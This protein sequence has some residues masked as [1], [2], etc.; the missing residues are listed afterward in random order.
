MTYMHTNSLLAC[1]LPSPS[2]PFL[3]FYSHPC[4]PLHYAVNENTPLISHP[5]SRSSRSNSN[6]FVRSGF[7][8]SSDDWG[9][10]ID[11]A[12]VFIND[13]IHYRSI[14]HKIDPKSLRLYHIYHSWPVQ[15]LLG[16]VIF[17]I[18]VLA[19]FEYPTSLTLSS[20]FRFRNTTINIGNGSL[21]FSTELPCGVT[22]FIEIVCLLVFLANWIVQLCLIGRSRFLKQPWLVV[23]ALMVLL[24]F[25][26]LFVS[27]GFCIGEGHDSLGGNI[28]IRR[29][30]RPFFFI[31]P[32]SIMKKFIKAV[33]HTLRRIWSVF[34]V[35][36]L[37]IYVFAMIGMLVF[38]PSISGGNISNTSHNS[39]STSLFDLDVSELGADSSDVSF[40][41]EHFAAAEG[42][43]W[44]KSVEDALVSL[45]VFLTTANNP[46]FMTSIYQY[47]RFSFIYFFLFLSIGLY[48]ILNL[49]TAAIF[50]EFRGF[51]EQSMQSSFIRRRVGFRAAFQILVRS[52]GGRKEGAVKDIVR[53]LIH[54]AN[55]PKHKKPK[56]MTKLETA[57]TGSPYISWE[58]FRSMLDLIS[59]EEG[60]Q[61]TEKVQYYS[62]NRVVKLLQTFVRHPL[63]NYFTLA[64]TLLHVAILTILMEA[65]YYNGSCRKDSI[66]AHINFFFFFYYTA[67][68]LLK[69]LGLGPRRFFTSLSMVFEFL[70]TLAIFI[71]EIVI[72]AKFGF[73]F[74]KYE[75]SHQ[76]D[77]STCIPI[78]VM[79][80]FVV[81]RL[82][83]I[84][85][86]FNSVSLVVGTMFEIL[87]NL[88]AFAGIFIVIYYM[89]ALLGMELFQNVDFL[90]TMNAT[91]DPKVNEC[92]TY[93]NLGYFAYNFHDFASSLVLLWNVMVVN[94]WYVFLFAYARVATKWSQLYFIAWWL[95]SVI[96]TINLFISLIIEV[97]LTRWEAYHS[98]KQRQGSEQTHADNDSLITSSI[99][100]P[101]SVQSDVRVILR[102]SLKEPPDSELL[103]ELHRHNELL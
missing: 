53:Q 15:I 91:K 82:L 6:H 45:L 64:M 87:K 92:G 13:A 96:I 42:R 70:I 72:L 34:V 55:L 10:A 19:F 88:R 5:P 94:N 28:R 80:V 86:V 97:F 22:E 83:R 27:L 61:T 57:N 75:H 78:R 25:I 14:H 58:E 16:V 46:D 66:L 18:L 98:W 74:V 81:L 60:E 93:E 84:I 49:F 11:Q 2:L 23:Y 30:F 67:E 103:H 41:E 51:L 3:P 100:A 73:P 7:H 38:P 40:M 48:L 95:V 44:F 71:T 56:L 63:F 65:D 33:F 101:F 24:S 54:T 76:G 31:V 9:T 90:D 85:P 17:V 52:S 77:H 50:T 59:K 26:D 35:L 68:Q 4:L 1:P 43:K 29:F 62:Q 102:K 37:H 39:T 32:S 89:F 47:N 99:Q 79:N 69:F 36:L 20:D 21:V 8:S 12:T